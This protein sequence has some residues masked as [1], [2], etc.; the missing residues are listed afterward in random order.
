MVGLLRNLMPSLQRQY[1]KTI[2]KSFC[3]LHLDCSDVVSN[4]AFNESFCQ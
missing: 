1:L 3:S 2:Y 4:K